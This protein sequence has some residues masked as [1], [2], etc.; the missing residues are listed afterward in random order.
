MSGFFGVTSLGPANPIGANLLSTL[1]ITSFA[2]EEF[3][4]QFKTLANW[5]DKIKKGD[6]YELLTRTYG[7]E[8][9]PEEINLFVSNMG[10]AAE[11]EEEDAMMMTWGEFEA[12][13]NQIREVVKKISSKAA[14]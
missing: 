11:G 9:M 10:L 2:N 12:K 14:M 7:F 1:G 13:L 8:P 4:A 3:H 6:V 5:Q